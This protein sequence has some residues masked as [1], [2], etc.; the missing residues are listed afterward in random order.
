MRGMC[1]F[2]S[3]LHSTIA[4][5][6]LHPNKIALLTRLNHPLPQASS[7]AVYILTVS[8]TD[9]NKMP[10]RPDNPVTLPGGRLVCVARTGS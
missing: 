4:F 7:P 9:S 6:H 3:E 10:W 5:P 1:M 8:L 2:L